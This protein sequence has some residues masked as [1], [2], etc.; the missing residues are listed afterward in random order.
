MCLGDRLGAQ[1]HSFYVLNKWHPVTPAT[2]YGIV[3]PAMEESTNGRIVAALHDFQRLRWRADIEHLLARLQGRSDDLLSFEEVRQR[4]HAKLAGERQLCEIPL[5]AIVGS[6]GRYHDF[7][8][9]FLPRRDDAWQ[10]WSRVMAAVD[11]LHGWPPIEVYQIGNAY[12]VIDGNHRVSVARQIGMD[13]I[14]AYVVPLKA[15]APVD[16]SMTLEEIIIAGE[17]ADFLEATRLDELRPGCDLRVTVAGQYDK[18]RQQIEH[19]RQRLTTA[20]H[21][22]SLSEAA[23]VWYDQVYRP[24]ADLIYERGLLRDFPQRSTTD[25]YLW[26]CDHRDELSK[27]LGWDISLTQAIEDLTEA[28]GQAEQLLERMIPDNL[29]PAVP[30]GVWRRNR[31]LDPASWLFR[32]VLVPVNGT[33]DGWQVLEQILAW[34]K[35]EPIRPLGI[36]VVRSVSQRNSV[37]AQ[38]VAR[39]FIERC[40]AAGVHG[41]CAIDVGTIDRII[42]ERARLVDLVAI[43]VN[44]PPGRSPLVR[45]TSG[46]RTILRCSVRPVLTVPRA[47]EHIERLLLAY[48]GSRKAEEALY[49]AT[50]LAARWQLSLNVVTVLEG[51]AEAEQVRLRAFRYLE[52]YNI[53]AGYILERGEP[54]AAIIHAAEQTRSDLV[55][56]GG[57]GHR[58]PLSDLVIGSTTEALL[59]S[60]RLPT[61]ICQ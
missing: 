21:T 49:L 19:I 33:P 40:A 6:V 24:I 25:L 35:R 2:F 17:Y 52:R 58:D 23:C 30:A 10:R 22:P 9:S 5:N 50:Y 4:V 13:H 15:R 8:R 60:R 46:L 28:P 45:L 54:A 42:R 59:R 1:P 3:S 48:D 12:F 29:E 7:N 38:A 20:D 32:E 44:H 51:K 37:A 56:M 43:Q 39:E 36:H 41:E 16:P 18:L 34:A 26:L 53:A 31:T 14:Q 57:Y 55:V 47:V 27:Q 11:S 61:I